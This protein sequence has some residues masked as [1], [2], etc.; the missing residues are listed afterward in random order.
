MIVLIESCIIG[1]VLKLL[2][3]HFKFHVHFYFFFFFNRVGLI[4]WDLIFICSSLF[5]VHNDLIS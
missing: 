2:T 3:F 4:W 5:D 1:G